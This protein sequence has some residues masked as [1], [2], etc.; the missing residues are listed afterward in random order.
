[1]RLCHIYSVIDANNSLLYVI[2]REDDKVNLV[3]GH[4]PPKY[5]I[6]QRDFVKDEEYIFLPTDKEITL[7]D[8]LPECE[9]ME[10]ITFNIM[11][12]KKA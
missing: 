5:G 11:L 8:T 1:M 7:L 10:Y 6:D 3:D 4:K 12:N 2:L 9:V